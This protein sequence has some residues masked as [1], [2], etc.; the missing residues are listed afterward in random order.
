MTNRR[1][2]RCVKATGYRTEAERSGGGRYLDGGER[3][4]HP[5]VTCASRDS[6]IATEGYTAFSFR[7]ARSTAE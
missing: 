3:K 7:C 2:T 1:F 5:S 4:Q 6:I